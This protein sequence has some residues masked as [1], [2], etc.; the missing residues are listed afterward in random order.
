MAGNK[1]LLGVQYLRAIAALMVAYFH[2]A[3]VEPALA[4]QGTLSSS[5]L[6]TGVWI[7]FVISGFIMYV[8]ARKLSPAEF[9]WRRIVRIVPL[10]WVLTVAVCVIAIFA[11]S[12]LYRTHV[13]V[14]AFVKSLLFIPYHNTAQGGVLFPLLVPGWT[15]NYE[16]AFYGLFALALFARRYCALVAVSVLCAFAVVGMTHSLPRMTTF[17]GFYFNSRL[18]L[19][20]AGII[21]AVAYERMRIPRIICA[22]LIAAGFW[23]LLANWQG[24]RASQAADFFGATA[25]LLGAVVWE[26]QFGLPEWRP[27]LLLGDASYSIYLAHTFAFRF[28]DEVWKHA[29]LQ[30]A[31][32][33]TAF[34]M[35]SMA[36]AI[37]LALITYQLIERPTLELVTRKMRQLREGAAAPSAGEM[38]GRA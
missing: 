32:S 14:G 5:R 2:L 34:G 33:A 9:A 38:P 20:A 17:F 4:F 37:G 23:L 25:I 36:A 7:F 29:W 26:R 22:A 12:T 1:K 28:T 11:P 13:T 21:I 31:A 6:P 35:V 30:G 24:M 27:L 18:L 15:L 8:T 10:Y 16:M 19:F 3:G